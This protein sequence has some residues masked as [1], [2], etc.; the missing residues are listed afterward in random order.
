[1]T[2]I[3]REIKINQSVDNV[4]DVLGNQFG[5]IS[6]WSSLISESKVYG[7]PKIEGL[8]YSQRETN[9]TQG[10]TVQE[11]TSFN[12]GEYSLSYKAIS[13]TPFFIK[14]TN[15]KWVLSKLDEECTQLNMSLDIQ[16]KGIIGF[17]LG[18]I[19]NIKLG[20]LAD[21]LVD[22]LKYFLENGNPHPRKVAA[23]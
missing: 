19:V 17:I 7:D 18:P 2:T 9:T 8:T 22:D 13:G 21:E 6:N 16:T 4:W 1:M 10:I 20:K 5:E 14:S 3:T 11:M 15:A 12:L 23:K